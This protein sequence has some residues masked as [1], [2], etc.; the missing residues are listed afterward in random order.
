MSAPL[1]WT[2]V[3]IA[4]LVVGVAPGLYLS[5]RGSNVQRLVGLQL[6]ATCSV[7]VLISLTIVVGQSSYLIV[8]LVLAV[9]GSTGTLVYTRLLK[10]GIDELSGGKE[11][12]GDEEL[13]GDVPGDRP[14]A[15]EPGS[16]RAA[17]DATR[18]GGS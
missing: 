11:L 4:L 6:L 16:N 3:T 5:L 17:G 2:G 10:P 15:D 7:L 13:S 9:L 18:G 1:V 12:S 8:P 14:R